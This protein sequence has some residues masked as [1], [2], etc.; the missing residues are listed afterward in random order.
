MNAARL[1]LIGAALALSLSATDRISLNG[2]WKFAPDYTG[3]GDRNN[4][5]GTA[6]KDTEWDRV[7]VPHVWGMDPRYPFFIG[8][9]WY[10]KTITVPEAAADRNLR[11][12]FEAVFQHATVWLNGSKLG[13]HEGGYTPFEFDITSLAQPGKPNLLVVKADNR[14]TETT[15]PGLKGWMDDGGIIRDAWL[16]V[17]PTVFIANQKIEAA[18]DPR[19]GAARIH[20]RTWVRN[21]LDRSAEAALS[22]D[23]EG[24]SAT[25]AARPIPAGATVPIDV[26]FTL[27]PERVRLW[28]L[29]QPS[30]Y[31]LT[32]RIASDPTPLVR[33]F[34]IRTFEVR[35]TQLLLNG[36]PIRLAGANRIPSSPVHGQDDPAAFAAEDLKLMKQ[37]GMVFARMSHYALSQ[38]VLD[39]AD[40]NGMLL[41]EEAGNWGLAVAQL[42]SPVVRASFQSQLQEMIER[43]W[44]RPSIVAWSVGN[45]FASDTPEGVQ[46]VKEMASLVKT[47]DLTRP[48]TFASNHMSLTPRP[49]ETEG[50][51]YADYV[52]INVYGSAAR[53]AALIDATHQ[54]YPNKPLVITEYGFRAD[55][56]DDETEREEWFRQ[57]FAFVRARPFVSG[58]SVWSF[59]DYR[60]RYVGTSPD[61]YRK[62]GMVDEQRNP[63]GSYF[64]MRHEMSGVQI[65][66]AQLESGKL[67]VRLAARLDFPLFPPAPLQLRI[68]FTDSAGRP[69]ETPTR[70]VELLPSGAETSVAISAPAGTV[71][72]RGEILRN[73]FPVM[74]FGQVEP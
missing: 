5:Q 44:N 22:L 65:K 56:M 63:R 11:L 23:V 27:P 48:I 17:S 45:E 43:D 12:R 29:D 26:D 72:F 3:A 13:E 18:P 74:T 52:S 47:F 34:G 67:T 30:L 38:S 41:V 59:N 21:T 24:A 66:A 15:I 28:K 37:A 55:L 6:V 57:M 4:W 19:T 58:L 32:T 39:W 20:V 70:P 36:Q 31:E 25:A 42:T 46:W 51:I 40:R 60:S 54:R 53:N 61:G 73:G 8:P 16:I 62:W 2:E 49:P 64:V 68:R 14:W 1:A 9:C 33:S 35:G 71:R 50:S 10:R 69:V 7:T